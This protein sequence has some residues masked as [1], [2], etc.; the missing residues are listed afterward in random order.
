MA[1]RT[2]DMILAHPR[3]D[4]SQ[5]LSYFR[6]FGGVKRWAEFVEYVEEIYRTASRVGLDPSILIAQAA[7]ETGYFTSYWWEFRLNPAG[8][9]I[10][11]VPAQNESSHVFVNGVE[12][13]RAHMTHLLL[14]AAGKVSYPLRMTDDPRYDAYIE[15]YGQKAMA[16]TVGDFGNGV[17]ARDPDYAQKLVNS[18]NTIFP[19]L[20]ESRR[21]DGPTI[22]P[23]RGTVPLYV[24]GALW[25]GTQTD[26]LNGIRLNAERRIVTVGVDILNVRVY[27]STQ[28]YSPILFTAVKG[29]QIEVIGWVVGEK[30]GTENRWWIGADHTRIW[31][32]GTIEKPS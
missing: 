3:G 15:A 21:A 6:R 27:A 30:V 11:G 29:Q 25:D 18:G 2:T 5:V 9:G 13:A 22:T 10:T 17:W 12:A 24:R 28:R 1:M 31:A 19:N 32:G 14:Y 4:V 26:T 20:E 16:D 7:H 8:L 23:A